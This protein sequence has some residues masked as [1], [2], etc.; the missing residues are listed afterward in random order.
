M[1]DLATSK[2]L[3]NA[4]RQ[5]DEGVFSRDVIDLAKT[6]EAYGTSI[7]KDLA[8]A[9]DRIQNRQGWLERCISMAMDMP[10]ALL[11]KKIRGLRQVLPA[12]I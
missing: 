2:L 1:L 7:A 10:K 8:K 6:T 12:A 5:A 4:D 3:A 11:W 9:I